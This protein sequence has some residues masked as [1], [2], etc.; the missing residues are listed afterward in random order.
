MTSMLLRLSRPLAFL[1]A[2]PWSDAFFLGV[3]RRGLLDHRSHDRLVRADPV[4][5]GVPLVAI[6]LQ[7]LHRAAALV[8]H[9]RHLERL[10]EP[11]RA[12]RFQLLVVDVEMLEA[13]AD[14]VACHRL[15][16]AELLLRR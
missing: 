13:P 10:H 12:E 4:G 7:E 2:I 9:A 1:A 15:A 6:P 5:D 16:L 11:G 8:V 3:F 14:L